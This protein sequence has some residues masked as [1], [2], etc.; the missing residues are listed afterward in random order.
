MFDLFPIILPLLITDIINPVLLAAVIYSLGSNKPFLKFNF[1]FTR[2]VF[3]LLYC[4]NC[5]NQHLMDQQVKTDRNKKPETGD[6]LSV[7]N[8][9]IKGIFPE[10]K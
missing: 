7:M 1:Y 10:Y 2:M 6:F 8:S 9:N 5:K 3:T 4:R